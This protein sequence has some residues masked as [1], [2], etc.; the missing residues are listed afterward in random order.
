MIVCLS[1]ENDYVTTVNCVDDVSKLE[2]VLQPM[3][4]L[5]FQLGHQLNV[6]VSL[7]SD[8]QET[9]DTREQ[10]RSLLQLCSDKGVTMMQLEGALE[11]LDQ[12]SLIPGVCITYVF[13]L[14]SE[15]LQGFSK[16]LETSSSSK[17]N[18]TLE[19]GEYRQY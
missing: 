3:E 7:L 1:Y 9:K 15:A 2:I 17:G 12:K 11:A 14:C 8:I 16:E 5:W 18:K 10:M 19:I 4:D 6:E 13:E